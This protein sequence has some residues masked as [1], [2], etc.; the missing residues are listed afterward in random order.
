MKT[1]INNVLFLLDSSGS[2]HP[3]EAIL[4]K[5]FTSLIQPWA[6]DSMVQTTRVSL[7]TFDQQV[8]RLF[9]MRH[10]TTVQ[11]FEYRA[12]GG[13]AIRDCLHQAIEDH[14][15]LLSGIEEHNTFLV[16]LLTDGEENASR[17]VTNYQLST[18][19]AGLST[20]WTIAALVPSVTGKHHAKNLGIPEGNID[21]WNPNA[22]NAV[23]EVVRRI[24]RSYK[25]YATNR[26]AGRTSSGSMFVDSTNIAVSALLDSSSEFLPLLY[27]SAVVEQIRPFVERHGVPYVIGKAYYQLTKTEHI[28]EQKVIAIRDRNTG[29]I[30][31]GAAARQQL[32]LPDFGT[33]KVVPAAKADRDKQH[34]D[35][36]VQSTSVNRNLM[37]GT[38]VLLHR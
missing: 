6:S 22:T 31:T 12:M 1:P 20:D 36:Y 13:T 27:T 38:S 16:Y 25:T 3:F 35:I 32:G 37:P 5:V 19:I 9:W 17:T 30:Y 21:V 23:E 2:M 34:L 29:K 7:Y 8:R 18:K 11:N 24:D 10:P 28:Q 33:V 14:R 4:P 15:L 26:A